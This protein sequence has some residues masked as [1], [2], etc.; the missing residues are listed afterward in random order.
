VG[1]LALLLAAVSSVTIATLSATRAAPAPAAAPTFAIDV[2]PIIYANCVTCHR[3]GQ[4]APFSLITYADVRKH[5]KT[6]V[7]V[8]GRH[9][10]PPWHAARAEGFAEFRDER[11]LSD[12]DIATLNAWVAAGMPSG[13][14]S[15]A[16]KPPICPSRLPCPQKGPISTG[17]SC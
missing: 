8:T 10:M 17:T 9:Y 11:H 6:I 5:G 1:P 13:N 14:L 3:P 7:D 12:R 2:A 16:P 4:A 15:K